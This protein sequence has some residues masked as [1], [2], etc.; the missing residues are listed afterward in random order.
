MDR[1]AK[2]FLPEGAENIG[3]TKDGNSH[4]CYAQT[5]ASEKHRVN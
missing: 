5:N 2:L 1:L 3:M 4:E